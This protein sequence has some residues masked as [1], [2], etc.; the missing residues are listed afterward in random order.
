LL[1]LENIREF[2]IESSGNSLE[3]SN[4]LI[5]ALYGEE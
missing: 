2:F 5:N 4:R 3:E 1:Y